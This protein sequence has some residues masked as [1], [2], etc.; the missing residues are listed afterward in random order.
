MM[1]TSDVP[2][3]VGRAR[4]NRLTVR[5]EG[6]DAAA[7][8]NIHRRLVVLGA[9]P[10]GDGWVLDE[11]AA[12][13]LLLGGP[14]ALEAPVE[15][16]V[17]QEARSL[18]VDP[19]P[20]DLRAT[21]AACADRLALR[22]EG[23]PAGADLV[24]AA[25][26]RSSFA[27]LSDGRVAVA[28]PGPV[29][30]VLAAAP[31]SAFVEGVP[32]AH[33]DSD[34]LARLLEPLG[35]VA[36]GAGTTDLFRKLATDTR[37]VVPSSV[38]ATL[39]PY[40]R[41]GV[42]RLRLWHDLGSGGVLADDMGLGKSLQTLALL[43]GVLADEGRLRALIVAPVSVVPN[44]VAEAQRFVPDL[45]VGVWHGARRLA[46]AR[47]TMRCHIVVT[48]YGLLRRDVST[49]RRMN[50]DY[51]ILDE[52]QQIKSPTS[53]SAR[54]ARALEAPHR[55]ALTGTPVEN[56]LAELWSIFAFACPGL[57]GSL[58][59]FHGAMRIGG[60]HQAGIARL[61]QLV[62]PFLLRRLKSEVATD[63]PEKT[64]VDYVC[65]LAPK[66]RARYEAE[67]TKARDEL[68]QKGG[69][70]T[71]IFA[72]LTRLRQ[73]AC[74]PRLVD[75]PGCTDNDSGK[76]QALRDLVAQVV[77]GG[78]KMIVFSQ[79][80]TMLALIRKALDADRV[81]YVYLDGK[82][83]DR[84][85]PVREFQTDPKASVFLVS[86][87]AGGAGLNLTAADNVVLFDPWWNPAVEAQAID[88]A[89]RI[90]Q[91]KP[92]TVYRMIS[93]G[94]IEQRVA[95]LRSRKWRV[96]KHVLADDVEEP[97]STTDLQELLKLPAPEEAPETVAGKRRDEKR[98]DRDQQA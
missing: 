92:V 69:D 46:E 93:H 91:R 66:Q 73:V 76:L 10:L 57:L 24:T 80:T 56:R 82:T 60:D 31:S 88:R 36:I 64:V 13:A 79:F 42:E 74:D 45:E 6:S 1:V 43:A 22:F 67:L 62:G 85:A 23:D 95:E 38:R 9:A 65:A 70:T 63:L 78:H 71:S 35:S 41:S 21:I 86:L 68:K 28:P 55:L 53:A 75:E 29:R 20:L 5:V 4:A 54:A 8:E 17:D 49:L 2:R 15:L 48:T 84:E 97:L 39:R 34:R 14:A 47:A 50:F 12:L 25:Q 59:H 26:S 16:D 7:V 83:R 33:G 40:Q 30:E 90:G 96:A 77:D 52:A 58:E 37:P 89:H 44:W 87:K 27:R 81:R 3:L 11:D 72:A 18:F 19:R 98:D 94:T 51:V 32:L 61:R